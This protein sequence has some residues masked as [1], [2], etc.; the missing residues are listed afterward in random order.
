MEWLKDKCYYCES[1]L[2]NSKHGKLR[3]TRDHVIP[4][5]KGGTGAGNYVP[6][7]DQCNLSKGSKSLYE[8][9]CFLLTAPEHKLK[10]VWYKLRFRIIKNIREHPLYNPSDI[11][12]Y[13]EFRK[14]MDLG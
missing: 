8:W 1:K 5:S 12:N 13:R 4:K 14:F 9:E 10:E 2:N 3:K 6:C 11:V 7:C